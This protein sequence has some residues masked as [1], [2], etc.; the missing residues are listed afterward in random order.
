MLGTSTP[1]DA[2]LYVT[3]KPVEA[4]PVTV[5]VPA[6]PAIALIAVVRLAFVYGSAAA[7]DHGRVV[8]ADPELERRDVRRPCRRPSWRGRRSA[9]VYWNVRGVG[10]A[11]IVTRAVVAGDADARDRRPC[12][13][14][15]GCA[16]P[17]CGSSPWCRTRSRPARSSVIVPPPERGEAGDRV[18]VRERARAR[19]AVDR[20]RAVVAGVRR[21]PRS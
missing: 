6:N 15:S 19:D 12:R 2:P 13:R 20:E 5:A 14:P 8:A 10:T 7:A 21:R 3:V 1:A 18:R 16:R 9:L 4:A 11:V 17:P